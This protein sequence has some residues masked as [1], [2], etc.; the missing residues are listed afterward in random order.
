MVVGYIVY[1]NESHVLSAIWHLTSITFPGIF[2]LFLLLRFVPRVGPK[3]ARYGLVIGS[4]LACWMVIT[5]GMNHPFA[6]SLHYMA[7]LP[8]ATATVVL[9]A[10]L[11]SYIFK[12]DPKSSIDECPR[13]HT[14][15]QLP[16][17]IFIDSL[18]PKPFY[19]LWAALASGAVLTFACFKQPFN[20]SFYQ[21]GCL[22][23]SSAL[24]MIVALF[25]RKPHF[26]RHPWA[27]LGFLLL[28]GC[29]LPGCGTIMVMAHPQ[30]SL[31]AW[32]LLS[33]VGVFGLIVGWSLMSVTTMVFI[34]TSVACA[35]LY[36]VAIEIP[37]NWP[38]MMIGLLAIFLY[39]ALSSAKE[40]IAKQK[41]LAQLQ[42]ALDKNSNRLMDTSMGI[43]QSKR[44]MN[45]QDIDRL[46]KTSSDL[47]LI[48]S[49]LSDTLDD[50]NYFNMM[51]L[52]IHETLSHVLTRFT[53]KQQEAL[54]LIGDDFQVIGNR[55][56]FESIVFH[57]LDYQ[58]EYILMGK[59]SKVICNL[60]P[61][62]RTMTLC[63]YDSKLTQKD[64][65]PLLD[66]TASLKDTSPAVL[67][68]VYAQAMLQS[69]QAQL[70]VQA[71]KTILFQVSFPEFI[72]Q[73]KE[74]QMYYLDDE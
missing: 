14:L 24:L 23:A 55:D 35:S 65:Q 73:P 30:S 2:G 22:L 61:K 34:A 48:I 18:K 52:S 58:L 21:V 1:L 11:L 6:F 15:Q 42:P 41:G 70:E 40:L 36:E 20:L 27:L 39:Y 64:L 62:K 67:S 68:I 13:H 44:I 10:W 28:L 33:L 29:A 60:N 5:I 3:A 17:N 31:M 56:A 50:S 49:A 71:N 45:F 26:Y 47:K 54:E 69:M 66:W 53:T 43:V 38:S 51:E 12:N 57:L 46:V 59:V 25:P 7:A 74:A 16:Q 63:H 9:S 72:P 37:S 8:I 4:L 19:R 32:L